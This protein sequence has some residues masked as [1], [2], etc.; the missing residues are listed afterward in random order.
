MPRLNVI[1]Q[2]CCT[3]RS[4]VGISFLLVL[5]AGPSCEEW[6]RELSHLVL[7]LDLEHFQEFWPRAAACFKDELGLLV[8]SA[9]LKFGPPRD[10]FLKAW[11]HHRACPES[12]RRMFLACSD[13][14]KEMSEAQDH[15][16]EWVTQVGGPLKVHGY[17]AV[18]SQMSILSKAEGRKKAA[19][20]HVRLGATKGKDGQRQ[21]FKIAPFSATLLNELMVRMVFLPEE[22]V[23]AEIKGLVTKTHI[24]SEKTRFC[25]LSIFSVFK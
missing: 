25:N 24:F 1:N 5:M 18:A 15:L 16:D 8:F 3:R 14:L 20:S 23:T 11:N 13:M 7:P 6:R 19:D 17:Q 4:P 22:T 21:L 9:Q 10:S 12:A 2:Q